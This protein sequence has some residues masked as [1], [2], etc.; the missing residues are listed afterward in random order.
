M[1][2]YTQS[3]IMIILPP[4]HHKVLPPWPHNSLLSALISFQFVTTSLYSKAICP[5][6]TTITN[7]P[8]SAAGSVDLKC[9]NVAFN[10]AQCEGVVESH[11]DNNICKMIMAV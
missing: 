8:F 6:S 5:I 11:S 4:A 10:M 7:L 2:G 3:H 9:K 1:H